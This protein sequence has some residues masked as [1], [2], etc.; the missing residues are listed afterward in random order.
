MYVITPTGEVLHYSVARHALQQPG[1]ARTDLFTD[2][3]CTEWVATVPN[4]WAVTSMAPAAEG[5]NP[6]TI[7]REQEALEE[8]KK[9]TIRLFGFFP[10][11][12]VS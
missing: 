8:A 9:R 2:E 6:V 7:V 1:E 11:F 3:T 12:S 5:F 10:L 4:T